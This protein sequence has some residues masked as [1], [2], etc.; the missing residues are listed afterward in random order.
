VEATIC[1]GLGDAAG[2]HEATTRAKLTTVTT[3]GELRIANSCFYL[4]TAAGAPSSI[5]ITIPLASGCPAG[6]RRKTVHILREYLI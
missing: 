2:L 1:V 6:S 3:R 5:P 4:A